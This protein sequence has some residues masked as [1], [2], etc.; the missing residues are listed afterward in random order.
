MKRLPRHR[1]IT[2]LACE[3]G[4]SHIAEWI[5]APLSEVLRQAGALP[6]ARYVVYH[7]IE[8]GWWDS[9]DMDEAP[10]P[11]TLVTYGMNGSDL[12]VAF[13]GPLRLRVP[14]SWATRA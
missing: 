11:Q 5:G 10:H 3:E 6:Q 9:I 7:S 1:Q 14:A 12:P 4:W 8:D 2:Q 13:G